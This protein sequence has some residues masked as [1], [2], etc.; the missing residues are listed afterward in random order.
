MEV[1]YIWLG[2]KSLLVYLFLINR[3]LT[4]LGF[5]INLF[6][7]LTP[8]WD[9]L[10]YTSPVFKNT[11]VY[12]SAMWREWLSCWLN[13]SCRCDHFVRYEGSMTMIGITIVGLM[14]LIRVY[15]LY[16][17]VKPVF[18]G[19]GI[20]LAVQV[21]INAWALSKGARVRHDDTDVHACTMIFDAQ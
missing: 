4:P 5:I 20:L 17:K 10:A 13:F 15:T 6:V 21:A 7:H 2:D 16:N 14:M 12:V 9:G 3:Y 19:V 8:S 18:A 1:D 11:A